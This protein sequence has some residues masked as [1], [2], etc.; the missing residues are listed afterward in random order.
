MPMTPMSAVTRPTRT[1]PS[2]ALIAVAG[3]PETERDEHQAE[4]DDDE[5]SEP[6][7]HRPPQS[8]TGAVAVGSASTTTAVP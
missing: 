7:H 6:E 2:V 5:P 1:R 4:G 8:S 3:G